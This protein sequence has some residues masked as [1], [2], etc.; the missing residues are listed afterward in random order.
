[1]QSTQKQSFNRLHF[2]DFTRGLVM[3]LM[4]WDHV[5]LFWMEIH[6]GGESPYLYPSRNPGLTPTLFLSRFIT[7]WCAPTFVFL[8]GVSLALSVN[9][10][11]RRGDTQT[12]ITIHII[13]RGLLLLLIEA[14]LISPV[15]DFPRLYFGVLATI[16]ASLVILSVARRLPVSVILAASLIILLNH[17]FLNLDLIPMDVA[18]GHYLRRI[19]YEPGLTW[20]PYF[21]LYPVI[22]WVG[23]MGLGWV[24]GTQLNR[25]ETNRLTV[26]LM[27]AGASSILLFFIV[28]YLNGYGNLIRRWSNNIL[29]WLYVSKY[30][31]SIA[32]LLWT[33][34][35]TCIFMAA[36]ILISNRGWTNRNVLGAI[37]TFGRVPLFFYIT[38][39]WTYKLRLPHIEPPFH[40]DLTQ[41]LGLYLVGL[42]V[43]WLFSNRYEDLKKTHPRLLQYI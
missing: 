16:G 13:K 30:P 43:L 5:T 36:G 33:L 27:A 25:A 21:S 32:F 10:R 8:S 31:P 6:G 20:Y 34:G 35:G 18:W 41:T 38:H 4:A 19:I 7:H 29:D 37:H 28:R 15:Y 17:E 39:L 11:L 24:F 1:M 42:V 3:I 40:L 26:P 22:P 9:N 12:D 2:I 23:I 14:L